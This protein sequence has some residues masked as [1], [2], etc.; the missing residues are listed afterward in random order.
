MNMPD[1]GCLDS[2][3]LQPAPCA[4]LLRPA[5]RTPQK[6]NNMTLIEN[7]R[8]SLAAKLI[9]IVE[10]TLF[11]SISIWAYF[12]ITYQK[13]K[14]M[15][16]VVE[17]TN[18][19]S[20]TIKLGTHYSMMLNSRDDINQIINN[21][22]RQEEIKNIRIYNK[23]GEIKFSNRTSE[24]DLKTNIKDEA[25]YICHRTE[26]PMIELGLD[27]RIRIYSSPEGY[28][29]LLGIISPIY[30][31]AGCSEGCHVH[32]EGKKILG[33]LDVVVSLEDTDREILLFQEGIIVLAIFVFLV[34]S[35]I[36]FMFVLKFVNLPIRKLINGTKRISKGDYS[37][38]VE[39]SQDDE[40]GEL[41]CAINQMRKEIGGK[42][43]ELNKQRDEYQNLFELVPCIITVQD[44]DYK[45]VRYNR[46]FADKF[47]PKPGDY[48][49]CA[50][51]GRTEKCEVCPVELTFE[52]G[53]SHYS[54]ETGVD[55]DGQQKHWI[56]KTSPLKNAEGKIIAAMEMCIDITRRKLLEEELEKSEKKYYAI[57]N[58][59]PNPLF[60]LD[61]DSLK[62]L[63]CNESVR[64]V[65]GYAFEET[66]DRTFL[67][68]FRSEEREQYAEKLKTSAV[69]S[70][71]KH[72]H[73]NGST[74]F[75]NIR[76][77]PSEYLGQRVLLVTT[78]DITKRLEAEQQLL[79]ASKMATLG[80]MA[81]GVAHELN[82]PLTV[83][84]TASSFLMKKI[85]PK[86]NGKED[87]LFIMAQK[88]NKNV[89]RASKIIN[90]MRQF[91]RKSDMGLEKVQ[92]NSVLEKA[93][94]MFSQQLK[95]RGIDVIWE[96][97]E[98]LP[99]IMADPDRLEQVFVNLLI[100][101][102]DAIEEKHS[103]A[104]FAEDNKRI[105][106]KTKS[107]KTKAAVEIC[108]S[109]TGIPDTFLDKVFE[110]FFTTKE[111]GKGTGIGLS[112]SYSIVKDFKGNI[113]AVPN[114]GGGAC[115][116]IE[117]PR[118]DQKQ[119]EGC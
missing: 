108:D 105:F 17:S 97:E 89:S 25:C 52:D 14:V 114:P 57:F 118:T 94:D 102:R 93:F 62:I 43:L 99:L 42:Q 47:A 5:I 103:S 78:S 13:E 49:F 115:F 87:S 82:Q 109:G 16:T 72:M 91:A 112:I 21:I 83:I 2:G 90:H 54:E 70:H 76:I 55:K 116:V 23:Q 28:H 111:V 6:E 53:V 61:T 95:L 64:T 59:S 110:P 77:S 65:Y 33:A 58:N 48:C 38:M 80:E 26:P 44:R 85:K 113:R 41:A 69:I 18:K 4:L 15:E 51:K 22:G 74:L 34:P 63:D 19:L 35:G 45:L 73:K 11:V 79:H 66:I 92:V 20:N 98:N 32:P 9:I 100:N 10:M 68:F 104:V 3:C 39:V 8:H 40:M 86:E 30:N 12:N 106:L 67:E 117:F 24:V 88:I 56:V 96:L 46:E 107:D 75:V 81:T 37:V 31:E 119:P 27:E 84:N 1:S 60:V 71:V 29:R 7:I 101:A 50:Y 36:I